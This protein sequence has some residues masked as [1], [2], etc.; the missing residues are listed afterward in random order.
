MQSILICSDRVLEEKAENREEDLKRL[1]S[2]NR[3]AGAVCRQQHC[4]G[5][6]KGGYT[7]AGTEWIDLYQ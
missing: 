2:E 7:D 4:S 5:K 1:F 6:I 3:I